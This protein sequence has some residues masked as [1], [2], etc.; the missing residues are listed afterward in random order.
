MAEPAA[1]RVD[2]WLWAARLFKTRSLAKQA[3][4][5]GKVRL[6]GVRAKPSKQLK[7]GDALS[8]TRGELRTDLKVLGL[9][10]KRLSAPLA[11]ALY[12]ETPESMARREAEIQRRIDRK[13]Q[14]MGP[15]RRP[16][17]RGRRQL[18]RFKERQ[19]PGLED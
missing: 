1:V 7:A 15:E 19:D 4:D 12:E 5:G 17:K 14:R 6:N 13:N 8:V 2:R 9:S 3:I 16:D 11:Q 10:E 18:R